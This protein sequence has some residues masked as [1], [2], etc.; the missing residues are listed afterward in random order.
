MSLLGGL[1]GLAF[2]LGVVLV[3]RGLTRAPSSSTHSPAIRR[4]SGL[5]TLILAAGV[6]R[7]TPATV[8]LTSLALAFASGVIALLVTAVPIVSILAAACGLCIPYLLLRRKAAARRAQ[9]RASWP[10]AIDALVSGIRAGMSLSGAL[11]DLGRLG[12]EPLRPAFLD[13]EQHLR[14]TGTFAEALGHLQGRLADPVADRVAAALLISHEVG[15]ADLGNV[16]RTLAAMLREDARTRG[17]I[18]ARQSWTINGA[19]LAVLAPWVTLALLSTRPETAAA[20]STPTGALIILGAAAASALA[21]LLMLRIARL[22]I[23]AR[24]TS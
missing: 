1:V 21:Y 19:R 20:Y 8:V 17:E 14:G 13:F 9:V 12:P 23:E 18:R 10:E 15:G 16:L 7:V 6:T 22:P 4:R 11:C 3:L 2:A 24:S 5:D